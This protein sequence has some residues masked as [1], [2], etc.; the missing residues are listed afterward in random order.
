TYDIALRKQAAGLM[1]K[2]RNGRTR[3]QQLLTDNK[4]PDD[5]LTEIKGTPA[6]TNPQAITSGTVTLNEL[7]TLTADA[8]NG[9]AVFNKSCFI[10]HQVNNEGLD[11]GPKLSEIG[12][13]L[14]K[15]S[16]LENI[17]HP[18]AGISFGYETWELA[19]KDGSTMTGI[20]SS[21]T[22]TDIT[23]KYPGGTSETVKTSNVKSMKELK[24][25]M[26]PE[27]LQQTM[28]R[29]D[30]ADLLEYLASLKKS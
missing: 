29:Q 7:L 13:K 1:G 30:L 18:S 5:I 22:S 17:I 16:L 27:G 26:M 15:E 24:N 14:P 23:L 20:I 10:C 28:S 3:V 11:F 2:S 12:S 8:K 6:T 4:V 21:K 9:K 19:M 25:S